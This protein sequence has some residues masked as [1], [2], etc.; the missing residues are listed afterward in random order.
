MRGKTQ[1]GKG[2]KYIKRGKV[3]L[4]FVGGHERKN[5]NRKRR[6]RIKKERKTRFIIVKGQFVLKR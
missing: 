3:I 6:E 5:P 1:I 4:V 2:E